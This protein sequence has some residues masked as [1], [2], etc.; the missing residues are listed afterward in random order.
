MTDRSF[1]G[2]SPGRVVALLCAAETLS[3]TGFATYPAMIPVLLGEWRLTNSEAGLISGTFFGGYMAAVPVLASLT[4][5]VDAKRVYLFACL[6]A[7]VGSF[8]F[9]LAAQGPWS[10]FAFQALVGAGLAGT[11][12][13]GLKLLS[14]R[15]EGPRRNRSVA[16]YTSTFGIGASLSLLLAAVVEPLLDWRAAFAISAV[17]PLAAGALVWWG[18]PA[19]AS[20]P[21][22]PPPTR[23][24]DFRHVFRNRAVT[25]YI[26]G[27]A[28]HCFELFGFRSWFV[29]FLAFSAALKP[30]VEAMPWT[31]AGVA[32]VVNMF[33]IPASILGNEI[34]GRYRRR[35]VIL[36]TMGLSA[37]VACAV[38]FLAPLP[39]Y[40]VVPTLAAYF[41]LIMGDSAALT[42][43]L[44]AE[45]SA[46]AR[47]TAMAAYSFLGFGAGFVAPLVFGAVLD[48]SGGNTSVVAW[49][50]AF[51]SLGVCSVLGPVALVLSRLRKRVV[52]SR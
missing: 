30:P 39:W 21:H 18:L 33:G 20:A 3:M 10:A 5:R 49:G 1:V 40:I 31:A 6:L 36:V 22:P 46:H 50:L 24:L 16:F 2:P 38:G 48:L 12:M 34:A 23:L 15:I 19:M 26:F 37:L 9:A 25:G 11:Y 32:A 8:G 28:A 45:A 14:D 44:V 17:G 42:N 27:Y 13:P 43:G 52:Q 35:S 47:G 29:A 7:A 4:D 41:M 51:A